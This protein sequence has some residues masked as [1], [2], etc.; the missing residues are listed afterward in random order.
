MKSYLETRRDKLLGVTRAGM[1][2]EVYF[3]ARLKEVKGDVAIF[4]LEQGKEAA[5]PLDKILVA[6]DPD[7]PGEADRR[8]PGFVTSGKDSA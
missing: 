7:R 2:K 5:V 6:G 3:E 8:A 4:E 1:P